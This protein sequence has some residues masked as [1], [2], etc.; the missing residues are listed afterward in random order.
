MPGRR[1]QL[2]DTNEDGEGE[3]CLWG[4]HVMMGYLGKE[5]KTE[6]VIDKE[7]FLKTGDIAKMDKRGFVFITGRYDKVQSSNGFQSRVCNILFN[8]FKV[9]TKV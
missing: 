4:R 2:T 1:S 5:D 7:G 8:V 9:L 6:E 3:L